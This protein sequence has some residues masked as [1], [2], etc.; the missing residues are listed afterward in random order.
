VLPWVTFT[1]PEVAHVGHNETSAKA[2][3][4]AFEVVRYGLGH[5]DR[6]VAE[7]AAEGFVKILVTP[8]SD[9]ILGATIVSH[10]GGELIAQ[11]ALAMKYRLGLKKILST[12]HAY[13]TM[14]EANKMAAGEWRRRHQPE[15][16]LAWVERYHRW[17]RR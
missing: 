6:A 10:N 16:L 9:S 15:R 13:P 1:D 2:A 14:S 5:L 7:S 3:G 17:R 12:V 8:G 11:I 4:I